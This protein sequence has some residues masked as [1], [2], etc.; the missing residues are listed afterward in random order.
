MII[1]AFTGPA[2]L[3]EE[4]IDVIWDICLGMPRPHVART[5]LAHG[6]DSAVA[7][8]L[9]REYHETKHQLFVPAA[10]H[11][12]KL[13]IWLTSGALPQRHVEIINCPEREDRASAYRR[14]NEMMVHNATE[15][16]AFVREPEFYRSGEWMTINIARKEGVPTTIYTI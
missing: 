1:R 5:G 16:V 7:E 14:R 11:N 15:L 3:T 8:C 13:R 9:Y 4:Q 2:T 10:P 12:D 6:V